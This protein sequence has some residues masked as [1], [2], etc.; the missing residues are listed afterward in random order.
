MLTPE[1]LTARI[2]EIH[3]LM[4]HVDP[5]GKEAAQAFYALWMGL[6]GGRRIAQLLRAVEQA[7]I[8]E[9]TGWDDGYAPDELI[10]LGKARAAAWAMV[11]RDQ[12]R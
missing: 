10:D 2:I 8:A 1:Q 11:A 6:G 4:R 5:T 9:Q 3:A 7:Y 12:Q